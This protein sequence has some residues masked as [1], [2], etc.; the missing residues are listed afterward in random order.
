MPSCHI[1]VFV[2]IFAQRT[3]R[4]KAVKQLRN[5]KGEETTPSVGGFQ[6]SSSVSTFSASRDRKPIK[7]MGLIHQL[8]S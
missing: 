1:S 5:V 4:K 2:I 3:Y 8:Q 6:F 7:F